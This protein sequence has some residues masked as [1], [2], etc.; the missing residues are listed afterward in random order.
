MQNIAITSLFFCPISHNKLGTHSNR[1]WIYSETS[2]SVQ[3]KALHTGRTKSR[4]FILVKKE[5]SHIVLQTRMLA[6]FPWTFKLLFSPRE[7]EY[8]MKFIKSLDPN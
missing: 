5:Q 1:E 6:K 7:T 8:A 3:Q 4:V 2:I